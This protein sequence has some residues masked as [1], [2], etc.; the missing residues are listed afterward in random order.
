ML[1]Y[2]IKRLLLMLPTLFGILLL[3]FL[4]IH[5]A[6][7]GPVEH[8]LARFTDYT[9]ELE[10]LPTTQN[11]YI[12]SQ[13]VPR[14]LIQELEKQ[15]GFDK[16]L[17]VRF[18]QMVKNYLVFNL[19]NSFFKDDTVIHI[20]L[21][22]LPVSISLGLW[23]TLLIYVI[24]IPLGIQ[25]AMH[26]H[27]RLD[28][29]SSIVLIIAY[30]TPAFLLAIL[31]IILFCGGNYLDWFPLRGL[32]SDNWDLLSWPE[33]I[34][35]Y[36][37]HI[38]LPVC[39]ITLS[40]FAGLTFLTKN[41]FL[42]EIHKH[43]VLTA[44]SK[45]VSENRVWYGHV[46]RN[47]MLVVIAGLP[48]AFMHILFTSA[49]LIEIIF[50]LEGLGLLG[51]EAAYTRDYPVLFGAVYLFTLIGLILNLLGDLLYRMVDPRIHFE[52]QVY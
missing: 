21:E 47:A 5:L 41:S 2:I 28:A 24:S 37:W 19:G 36:L 33:R 14:E 38:T 12:G 7:G 45:G 32:T 25:K 29:I 34:L 48:Q 1:V 27:S 4:I 44:R 49:L 50:S 15:F 31:F 3:N 39:A 22:R 26:H 10:T 18:V 6:P 23:A 52:R 30:A 16:P 51:F 40:G 13:G 43:Y 17:L 11:R 8:L 46:F 35:D 9:Q 42:E 20:L